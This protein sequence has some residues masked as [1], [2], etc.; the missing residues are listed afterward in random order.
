MNR[1]YAEEQARQAF[2]ARYDMAV[3]SLSPDLRSRASIGGFDEA[4]DGSWT[5]R[6]PLGVVLAKQCSVAS[7]EKEAFAAQASQKIY[8]KQIHEIANKVFSERILKYTQFLG[9]NLVPPIS[10]AIDA[11]QKESKIDA[12]LIEEIVECMERVQSLEKGGVAAITKAFGAG[13]EASTSFDVMVTGA[14]DRYLAANPPSGVQGAVIDRDGG[15]VL[16]MSNGQVQKL[17]RVVGRDGVSLESRELSYDAETHEVVERWAAGETVREFRYP[18]G[19]IH[20]RGYWREGM[21]VLAC[22]AVTHGGSL[23]IALRDTTLPPSHAAKDDWRLG[24]RKGRD[25]K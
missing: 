24:A 14:V 3:A 11:L 6:D 15:L 23:W 22:E 16:T 9:E 25:A 19:G 13:G 10:K 7:I 20:D 2:Y 12:V 1:A 5:M 8:P 17:G 21:K 4:P 18:A